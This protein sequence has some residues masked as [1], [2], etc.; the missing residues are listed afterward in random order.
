MRIG[1]YKPFKTVYFLNDDVDNAAWSY[2]VVNTFK[3][4]QGLGH[5]VFMLSPCDDVSLRGPIAETYDR[6]ILFS[7]SFELDQLGYDVVTILRGMTQRLDFMLT[8]MRLLPRKE[9]WS[10]FDH[11]YT[12]STNATYVNLFGELC[13]SITQARIGLG[14]RHEYA[15]IAELLCYGHPGHRN[16]VQQ[17]IDGKTIELY[18]G[19]TERGRLK[20]FL[21]FVWR[22]GHLVTTKSSSL[23]IENRT[24]RREYL[25]TVGQSKFSVVIADDAYN[26]AHFVTPRPYEVWLYDVIGFVQREFDPDGVIVPTD[27]YL[28]VDDYIDMRKKM[29][30][31]NQNRELHVELLEWQR[32]QVTLPK[33]KGENFAAA[34]ER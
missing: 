18:F 2:E 3:I 23:G 7:G 21:E 34:V 30:E 33:L 5:E 25:R 1:I 16:T 26:Q 13:S 4:L 32:S 15:H 8:D 12:Q 11:V 6:I 9:Q 31:I 24:G 22:P 17:A 20:S 14:P 28:R 27:H 19:G 10:Y 29:L